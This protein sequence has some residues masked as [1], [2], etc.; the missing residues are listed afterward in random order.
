VIW[1]GI[2]RKSERV[3]NRTN[4][5]QYGSEKSCL[6]TATDVVNFEKYGVSGFE[7]FYRR[8]IGWK[9]F[10]RDCFHLS[11]APHRPRCTCRSLS[12]VIILSGRRQFQ[13]VAIM[14]DDR[15]FPFRVWPCEWYGPPCHPHLGTCATPRSS[16]L[17]KLKSQWSC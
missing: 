14:Y 17:K 12:G 6:V 13:H 9:A 8:A 5:T 15:F 10:C 2:F 3:S 4:Q 16:E 7:T 11:A 1:C